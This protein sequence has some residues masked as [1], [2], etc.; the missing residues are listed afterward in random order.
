ML[1]HALLCCRYLGGLCGHEPRLCRRPA[2]PPA[3][4]LEVAELHKA[5]QAA[6]K[7]T[8]IVTFNAELD[9]IRT[10]GPR[11]VSRRTARRCPQAAACAAGLPS[12]Q[13]ADWL[14]GWLPGCV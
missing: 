3:E 2:H 11:V 9:R 7:A 10:G 14:A 8:P 6:G 4:M 13:L 12:A 1:V 5:L